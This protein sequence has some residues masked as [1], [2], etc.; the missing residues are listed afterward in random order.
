MSRRKAWRFAGEMDEISATFSDAG[1]PGG[2][3]AAAADVYSRIAEFKDAP[4][5][6]LL[7][8]VLTALLS[9]S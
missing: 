8:E 5:T 4:S 6:P 1:M 3:H 2:F 7:D 9:Q